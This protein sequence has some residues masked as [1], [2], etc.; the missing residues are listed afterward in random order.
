MRS[1]SSDQKLVVNKDSNEFIGV[2]LGY[3]YTSEHEWGF[4]GIKQKFGIPE[5]NKDNKGVKCRTITKG[6]DVIYKVSG[7]YALLITKSYRMT[8]EESFEDLV[9]RDISHYHSMMKFM[10]ED[11]ENREEEKKRDPLVTAWDERDFCIIV[12]GVEEIEWLKQLYDAFKD[13]NIVVAAVN[14]A[15]SNTFS[16]SS[17]AI[18]IADRLPK[19]VTDNLYDAD[20]A[21]YILSDYCDKIGLTK[22][23]EIKPSG[24]YRGENYYMAL[25]PKPISEEDQKKYNT[26][27]E[28]II[29]NNYSDDDENY[30]WYTFEDVKKWLTTD[31]LKLADIS[32][33][34]SGN[35]P[36]K[37]GNNIMNLD[38]WI[39]VENGDMFEGTRGQFMDCFFSN[40]ND[41]EIKKWCLEN[42][43]NLKIDE[44][45]ILA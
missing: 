45:T 20:N 32:L 19:D 21:S 29:W 17:L 36:I 9:P 42:K 39:I 38:T 37:R 43:W 40:A 44:E 1:T 12:N 33:Q 34:G 31:G 27:Y 10:M 15:P 13:N 22:L 35:E 30:G 25:S 24:G 23:K 18:A 2:S 11:N 26:K 8:G 28:I 4:A 5:S 6:Q 16:N 7:E 3:D 14:L 41:E